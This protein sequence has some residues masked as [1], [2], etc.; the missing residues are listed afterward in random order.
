[1]KVFTERTEEHSYPTWVDINWQA[2]E[3]NVR[4]LQERIYRANTAKGLS[5]MRG[6]SHVRLCVQQ[7]LACAVGG[8][9]TRGKASALELGAQG[10]GKPTL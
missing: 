4:R 9:P 3:G 5:R 7:R 6:N 1:V 10:D 8:K 2:V